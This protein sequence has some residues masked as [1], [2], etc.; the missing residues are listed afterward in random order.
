LTA[1]FFELIFT[2]TSE[3]GAPFFE[4]VTIP[5]MPPLVA[6]SAQAD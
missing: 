5:A 3:T 1:L 4:S 2:F 6:A